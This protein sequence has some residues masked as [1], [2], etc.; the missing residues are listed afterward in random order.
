MFERTDP[1][2]TQT[3]R[4]LPFLLGKVDAN[5][6]DAERVD[7]LAAL[8]QL[9]SAVAAAQARITVDFVESQE[10]VARQ[11]RHRARECADDNDFEG[12]RAAR[13]QARRAGRDGFDDLQ[14]GR[15]GRR[16]GDRRP[17]A[18]LGVDGQVA[19]ARRVSPSRGSRLVASA[20]TLVREM[21][22]TM[23]ALQ[24]GTLT[25]WR[26]EL[27]TRE[28]AVLTPEQRTLVDAEL[29]ETLGDQLGGIGD[30]ELSRRVRAI[31][32]RVD[33]ASVLNRCRGAETDRRLSVRPAPD[34]MAYLTAFLPVA[35]AVATHAALTKAAATAR[36]DGDERT[37][38]QLMADTLVTRVTGQ[39][40]AALAPVEI[41]L[42]MTDRTL[43]AGDT[44]PAHVLGYGPVPAG[45]ARDLVAGALGA[46]GAERL[47][48]AAMWLRRLYTHPATGTLVAMDSARRVFEAGLRRFLVTRDGICRT[49]WCD[50][51]IQHIDH[52]VDHAAGGATSADNGQGYCVRC[53]HT[54]QHPGWR[55]DVIHP[56][57]V[58]DATHTV[59]T[60]TP[61]GH[62]YRSTAPPVIAGQRPPGRDESPLERQYELLLAA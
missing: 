18:D 35:Q 57:V 44:T 62:R 37:K 11:W 49:P 56:H 40:D 13:E 59:I 25:E 46:D 50:A 21:P 1:T 16:P 14:Q 12:W 31:A 51:P 7:Q 55:T 20:L 3:L 61:T 26:A 30:K 4:G 32:Y 34:A 6:S 43:L 48:P 42:V 36:A 33:P 5:I 2:L 9:K 27:V 47:E 52:V 58:G 22:H 28:V 54:K 8:E 15:S 39:A 53:N 23:A 60:T 19:L 38:G 45:W 29:G 17:G 24:D 41:Q 10:Q